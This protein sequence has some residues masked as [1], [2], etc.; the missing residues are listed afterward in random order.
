MKK[1]FYNGLIMI[2]LFG[3]VI[4]SAW[5]A[6]YEPS[7]II[8]TALFTL[9]LC[10][11]RAYQRGIYRELVTLL[12]FFG[13][14]GLGWY[15]SAEVGKAL[16]LPAMVA[17]ISGFYLTFISLYLVSGALIRWF[18]K[19]GAE[20][21]IPEKILGGLLGGFEGVILAWILIF[22]LSLLPRSKISAYYPQ[23]TQ[24]TGPVENMLAPIMPEEAAQ[25]VQMV[26][27]MQRITQN[28]KP[29]KVDKVALQE[30]MLPLAEMP[31]LVALQEDES[32][33]KLIES[34]DFQGLVNHP[35]LRNF[36]ESEELRQRMQ[37]IDLKKL[38]R[39]LVPDLYKQTDNSR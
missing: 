36:L 20:L 24:F 19:K 8:A 25:T 29:E 3:L 38:E 15:L 37:S 7:Y 31:E 10:I 34:R 4:A 5:Q 1:Q 35:T 13:S 17:S 26:K 27:S 18:S 33:Q 11:L 12:R 30:I 6:F 14:L 39:A 16:G 28:F 2:V 23:L 22:T 9:A 21:S 32:I